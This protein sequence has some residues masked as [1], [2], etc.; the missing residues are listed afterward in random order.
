MAELHPKNDDKEHQEISQIAKDIVQ[1]RSSDTV[2]C[3]SFYQYAT[4]GHTSCECGLVL[5]GA[6]E[7]VKKQVLQN[8]I[9]CLV[10]PT[11]SAFAFKTGKLKGKTICCPE[12]SHLYHKARERDKKVQRRKTVFL[13][14]MCVDHE[15]S[16]IGQCSSDVIREKHRNIR[17]FDGYRFLTY[18]TQKGTAL[19]DGVG[20][21]MF[22][23]FQMTAELQRNPIDNSAS[24]WICRSCGFVYSTLLFVFFLHFGRMHLSLCCEIC[25]TIGNEMLRKRK[26]WSRKGGEEGWSRHEYGEDDE[27][28]TSPI[29]PFTTAKCPRTA[30]PAALSVTSQISTFEAPE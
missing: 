10:F 21:W 28:H 23:F 14:G 8:V 27:Q 2:Q 26:L 20:W 17:N 3:K 9:N 19:H 6:S 29:N 4:P 7:E 5:P 13:K 16:F 1:S 22:F 11:T 25:G 12:D 24:I 15:N 18:R 30:P